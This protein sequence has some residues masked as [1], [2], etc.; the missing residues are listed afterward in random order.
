MMDADGQS[1]DPPYLLGFGGCSGPNP[2]SNGRRCL[3]VLDKVY[4]RTWRRPWITRDPTNSDSQRTSGF[5]R[6][7]VTTHRSGAG[8][9]RP[10]LQNCSALPLCD[11]AVRQGRLGDRACRFVAGGKGDIGEGEG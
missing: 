10:P 1:E 11:F 5:A 7:V 3:E 2:T 8:R 6:S 9:T 4:E